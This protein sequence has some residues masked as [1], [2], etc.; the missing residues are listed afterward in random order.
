MSISRRHVLVAGAACAVG[1]MPSVAFALEGDMTIGNAESPVQLIEYASLTCPHCAAF[2][3]RIF[4]QLKSNYIDN[5][6]IGFTLREYPT[7]PAPIAFAMFQLARCGGVGPRLYF[8]RVAELFN[9]Q[10]EVMSSTTGAEVRNVLVRIG[11][12]WGLSEA[13]VIAAMQDEAAVERI[14]G[15]MQSGN[16][17]NIPGTPSLVLNGTLLQGASGTSY[18]GL[19]A[20]LDAAL[21]G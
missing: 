9:R 21:A 10:R 2:H 7:A 8:D 1:A 12:E 16:A 4:P 18:D 20:A 13:D 6:R 17:L 19:S 11:A 14:T 15:S 3:V 5:N